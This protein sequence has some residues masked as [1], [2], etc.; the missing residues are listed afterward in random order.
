MSKVVKG[1]GRAIGKVVGGAVHLVKKVAT[2]KLGKI[3]IGAA[4]MY[5]GVPAAM[6]LFGAGGAAAA[7]GLSGLAG[8]SANIGAAWSSL[9]AAGSSLMAGNL[10]GAGSS[11]ASGIGGG[12]G[13]VSSAMTGASS[14]PAYAGLPAGTAV[15]GAAEAAQMAGSAGGATGGA[16]TNAGFSLSK[17]MA[18]PYAAPALINAGSQ[19][20]GGIG[21]AKMVQ[22]QNDRQDKLDADARARYNANVGTNLWGN[23]PRG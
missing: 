7:G 18:S 12:S 1:V 6:G 14:A 19:V 11:I 15:N 22:S 21:Q 23:A 2:S 20:V 4:A 5:F 9:G 3:A 16:A 13:L 10:S 8:A 17:F